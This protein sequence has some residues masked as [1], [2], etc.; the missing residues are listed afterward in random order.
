MICLASEL[1]LYEI[2]PQLG[3][4]HRFDWTSDISLFVSLGLSVLTRSNSNSSNYSLGWNYTIQCV[5]VGMTTCNGFVGIY[6]PP[7]IFYW[8]IYSQ[9]CCC[10][11][12]QHSCSCDILI[13]SRLPPFLLLLILTF[14][15]DVLL[16]DS[17]QICTNW[18]LV[19]VRQMNYYI[20]LFSPITT[21][22]KKCV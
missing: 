4:V 1:L 9:S 10:T 19:T 7:K 21:W 17:G 5:W 11:E 22:M 6:F 13:W 14:L 3:L 16:R 12:S 20:Y 18:I 8:L 15:M 2:I